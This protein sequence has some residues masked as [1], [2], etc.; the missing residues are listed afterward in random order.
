MASLS[1]LFSGEIIP[2]DQFIVL[3]LFSLGLRWLVFEYHGFKWLRGWLMSSGVP[4]L[5]ALVGCIYCQ[6]IECSTIVYLLLAGDCSLMSEA[7]AILANGM[8][9]MTI[10]P[11]ADEVLSRFEEEH[12]DNQNFSFTSTIDSATP[13]S[14]TKTFSTKI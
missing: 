11:L 5:R 1:W 4:L 9:A 8:L 2:L 6:T 12:E 10:I 13:G 14:S 7:L 3:L